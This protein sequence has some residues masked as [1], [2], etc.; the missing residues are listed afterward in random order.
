MF[1]YIIKVKH[2]K[3]KIKSIFF[4]NFIIYIRQ[5]LTN[6]ILLKMKKLLFLL[7][8]LSF[9]FY[10]QH[11]ESA[12]WAEELI[13]NKTSNEPIKMAELKAAFDNYFKTNDPNAKGSG[14][15]PFMRWYTQYENAVDE[16]GE[17][18]TGESFW[19]AWETKENLKFQLRNSQSNAISNWQPIG[20][21]TNT[22]YGNASAGQ[23]RVNIIE[24]D[25]NNSNTWYIGTPAGGIWKSTNAG[26]N[27]QPLTDF[28]PQ[29]GV[30]GI[31]IDPSNS[32]TIYIATGDKDN[33]DSYSFGIFKSTNGG[34]TWNQTGFQHNWEFRGL[35]DLIINPNSTNTLYAATKTGVFRTVDG[36]I[37]WTNRRSGNFTQGNIRFKTDDPNTIFATSTNAFFKS[38]NGGTSFT[39]VT[40]G[41]PTN[42]TRIVM[43][44]TANDPNYIYLLC[45]SSQLHSTNNGYIG[46]YRSTN[47]GDS[48][49]LMNSNTNVLEA[50]QGWFDL[51]IS[52]S[53]TNKQEIY[54]GALNIW[55]STNGG[56]SL[57]KVNNWSTINATYT[58]AD[59][60]YLGF[61]NNLLFCGSDGG[62][63]VSNAN[64]TAFTNKTA[65]AQISQMYKISS[66]NTSNPNITTGLQDNGGFRMSNNSW[67]RW[68]GGDGMD[69]AIHQTNSNLFYAFMQYGQR[70]FISNNTGFN[71]T[72]WTTSPNSINGNWV[73][74]LKL[75]QSNQLFAG[76]DKLYRLNGTTSG[77]WISHSNNTFSNN[78]ID[79]EF[80]PANNQIVYLAVGGTFHKSTDGGVNFS[81]LFTFGNNITSIATHQTNEN[82]VY[83]TTSNWSGN[84]VF[85][86][87][88]G[89]QSFVA[90]SN[91]LPYVSVSIIKHQKNHPDDALYIGTAHGVYYKDNT[92][93]NWIPFDTNLP[94]VAV[95]DLEINLLSNK[96]YAGTFGRGLW[97]CELPVP[98]STSNFES[99]QVSIYPNPTKN[100][101]NIYSPIEQP[102]AVK[103]FD[104]SGKLI[105][106]N[107]LTENKQSIDISHLNAGVYLMKILFTD[108]EVTH[109]VVKE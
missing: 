49:Q 98:L 77:N 7:L 102:Q 108:K 109:K 96:I 75:N 74:P 84:R 39:Q 64:V 38:T 5:V 47:A 42:A 18:Q 53:Q 56:S 50:S 25:P 9:S 99:T 1:Y 10:G 46:I 95:R 105:H 60:H 11:N 106:S 61:K 23:G 68:H 80:H 20:P 44:V 14:H 57:T 36:G 29:I 27:W 76:F 63:Y 2:F 65:T 73:T 16:N 79:F 55:K 103:L 19:Q 37:T 3:N 24:V 21:F 28:L 54:T 104:I 52:A 89:G 30:S 78:I 83:V 26:N 94:N 86:S 67:N 92:L 13:K 12:P 81:S 72:N 8:L 45:Y 93:T 91:G 4:Y 17:L 43:D 48:F 22:S 62:I 51:A 82:I 66:S 100:I 35:G 6:L 34:Q 59:I 33:S 71:T 107:L 41:L 40:N 31:A 15:K 101:I 97:S 85:Q 70:L 87:N 88:N 58:H 69:N 90:I 32:N